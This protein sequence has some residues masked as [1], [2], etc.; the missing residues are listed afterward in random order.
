MQRR[1]SALRDGNYTGLNKRAL[2]SHKA[3]NG[4]APVVG[5]GDVGEHDAGALAGPESEGRGEG[6]GQ[7]IGQ[8]RDGDVMRHGEKRP[9]GR[10]RCSIA[11]PA[12]RAKV[13]REK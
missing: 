13:R 8:C 10:A 9:A 7:G 11:S 1:Q 6:E 12:L 2:L 5:D 3:V 4:T